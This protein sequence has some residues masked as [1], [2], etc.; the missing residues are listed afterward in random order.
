MLDTPKISEKTVS[1]EP[2]SPTNRPWPPI[3]MVLATLFGGLA[4]GGLLLGLNWARFGNPTRAR[5]DLL[6]FALV[7]I[8]TNI[9]AAIWASGPDQSE[10]H[11]V[12]V[13]MAM[14]TVFVVVSLIATL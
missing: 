9:L 12:R 4:G 5:R 13:R 6:L 11:Q 1:S 3:P 8:G 7:T 10:E 14:L 2:A